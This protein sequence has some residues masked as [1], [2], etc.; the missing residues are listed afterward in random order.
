MAKPEEII[1][2][3][4]ISL[5][6]QG[7]DTW[8]RTWNTV[9]TGMPVNHISGKNYQGINMLVLAAVSVKHTTNRWLTF[10]QA[11][12]LGG[13]I[14]KGAKSM[15]V[16]F[17]NFAEKKDKDGKVVVN[18]K[19]EK[20]KI[21][22]LKFYNVFNLDQTEGI[23]YEIPKIELNE[24]EKI[25][26]CEKIASSYF[27]KEKVKLQNDSISNRA[28]YSLIDD[29]IVM[30]LIGQFKNSE[31][32]YATLFH[33]MIHSTGNAKRLDR[34]LLGNPFG[35]KEYAQ[36]ELIAELGG[37]FLC[38]HAGIKNDNLQN[39]S[40][41]YLASWLSVCKEEP[42]HIIK[43]ASSAQKAVELI[44]DSSPSTDTT[45]EQ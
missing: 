31:S 43:A 39:N 25:A 1:V 32:Y 45:E 40:A 8:Q 34:G 15:P 7:P 2:A 12:T 13:S 36:E 28:Y 37:I 26:S 3:S 38:A 30:P 6:E 35:S 16:A 41:S 22:F 5:M 18:S 17:W 4:L 27:D 9:K 11:Q 23:E 20:E 19:G 29:E 24:N 21:P 14:R 44:L 10:K 33:E 42:K